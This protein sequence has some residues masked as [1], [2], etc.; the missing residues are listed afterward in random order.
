MAL[1][2]FDVELANGDLIPYTRKADIDGVVKLKLNKRNTSVRV[3]AYCDV[4][5][6]VIK[7]VT[8]K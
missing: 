2:D 8:F 3:Q 5:D 4:D 1:V 7:T 6:S